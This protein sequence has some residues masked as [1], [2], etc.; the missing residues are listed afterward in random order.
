MHLENQTEPVSYLEILLSLHSSSYHI[1]TVSDTCRHVVDISAT[2]YHQAMQGTKT[3]HPTPR[4][5]AVPASVPQLQTHRHQHEHVRNTMCSG[6]SAVVYETSQMHT[7]RHKHYCIIFVMN[8]VV[9]QITQSAW[10]LGL[11]NILHWFYHQCHWRHNN[12]H[13]TGWFEDWAYKYFTSST[14]HNMIHVPVFMPA[15]DVLLVFQ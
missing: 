3:H 6:V 2:R 7:H 9:F 13:S 10:T 15:R 8:C 12:S 5:D 1:F 14:A 4:S 11:S